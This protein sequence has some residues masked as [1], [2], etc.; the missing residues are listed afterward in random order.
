MI[1]CAGYVQISLVHVKS[2]HFEEF[3][4]FFIVLAPQQKNNQYLSAYHD[5]VRTGGTGIIIK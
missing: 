5:K 2:F 4:L 3:R 1:L